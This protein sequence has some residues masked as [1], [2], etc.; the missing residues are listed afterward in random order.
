MNYVSEKFF[1]CLKIDSTASFFSASFRRFYYLLGF[2][3]L[4]PQRE[5]VLQQ[6]AEVAWTANFFRASR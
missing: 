2:I 4:L 5:V 6:K 1:S 3:G